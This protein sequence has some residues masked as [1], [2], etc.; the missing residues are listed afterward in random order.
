MGPVR[1]QDTKLAA[2]RPHSP[3][4]CRRGCLLL[5]DG[6]LLLCRWNVCA[7]VAVQYWRRHW[8][9]DSRLQ[10]LVLATFG[11]WRAK[12]WPVFGVLVAALATRELYAQHAPSRWSLVAS[13]KHTHRDR[14][15]AADTYAHEHTKCR[16]APS[17][18]QLG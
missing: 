2:R 8:S 18:F 6:R 7:S 14:H 15:T 10:S 17:A 16:T 4:N 9:L 11:G 12:H 5:A 1:A 13:S 3:T